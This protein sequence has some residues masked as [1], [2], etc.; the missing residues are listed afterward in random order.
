MC[1]ATQ[2]TEE[3]ETKNQVPE[4]L[5]TK[6]KDI[7]YV[8]PDN[9][10]V[11]FDENVRFDYGDLYPMLLSIYSNGVIL[12]IR[13]QK[14]KEG[15]NNNKLTHGFR[16]MRTVY[17]GR[18]Y[19][20]WSELTDE[21]KIQFIVELGTDKKNEDLILERFNHLNSIFS[22]RPFQV[23]RVPV[24]IENRV[25]NNNDILYNHF[26]LNEENKTLTNIEQAEMFKTLIMTGETEAE[27]ALRIGRSVNYVKSMLLVTTASKK[28]K[29]HIINKKISANAVAKI[30]KAEAEP[31]LQEAIAENAIE[32][33]KA[34][35]KRQSKKTGKHVPAKATF[36][37]TDIHI[38]K[39]E[40]S[41]GSGSQEENQTS[42]TY[43]DENL[44]KADT[45]ESLLKELCEALDLDKEVLEEISSG[46][47]PDIGFITDESNQVSLGYEFSERIPTELAK[48]LITFLK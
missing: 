15:T 45:S 41:N 19:S 3:S 39:K 46:K 21:Q 5:P 27:I 12:P 14:R 4:T 18:K 2:P 35:A 36:K 7:Y 29:K 34:R 13:C 16:R 23:A 33:A 42:F 1:V 30:L 11:N 37:D 47:I 44:N 31:E 6:R 38:Q 22:Q 40:Q 8:D 32:R 24:M 17:L 9:I 43:V 48:K 25:F 26:V 28:I 20:N 10:E